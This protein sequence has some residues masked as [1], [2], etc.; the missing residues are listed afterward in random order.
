MSLYID[1]EPFSKT[2]VPNLCRVVNTDLVTLNNKTE[3][4]LGTEF[5]HNS[6][7]LDPEIH[8]KKNKEL[9]EK[10]LDNCINYI[11]EKV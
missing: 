2:L 3:T 7:E 4:E 10:L 11:G 5:E 1:H 6:I 8:I 9:Y